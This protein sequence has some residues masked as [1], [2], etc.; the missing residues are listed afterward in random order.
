[1]RIAL[2]LA[3]SCIGDLADLSAWHECTQAELDANAEG[4][5]GISMTARYGIGA[6]IVVA[7][8]LL[9]GLYFYWRR[10]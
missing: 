9:V 6:A 10:R 8:L 7:I 4:G 1:L 5:Y 2:G 3:A